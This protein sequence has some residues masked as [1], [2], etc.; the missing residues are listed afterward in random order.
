MPSVDSAGRCYPF[1]VICEFDANIDI[2]KLASKIDIC[3]AKCEEYLVH[4]LNKR[5]PDLTAV[6]NELNQFYKVLEHCHF[7]KVEENAANAHNVIFH[8]D[9]LHQEPV[10]SINEKFLSYLV[11][12]E[13]SPLTIWSRAE[14]ESFPSQFRYYQGM[15]TAQ[16]FSSFLGD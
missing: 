14:S 16:T 13:C 11:E 9:A 6:S 4:L 10:S 15:P 12:Q 8:V 1:F 5:R 3:H 7:P 2:F